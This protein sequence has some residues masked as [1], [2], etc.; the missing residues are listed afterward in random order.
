MTTVFSAFERTASAHGGKPFLEM[1]AWKLGLTYG[2]ALER[3]SGIAGRYRARGY[4]PGHRVA[5]QLETRPEF[6]LHFLAL[7]S[8]GVAVLPLNPDYRTAELEYV[9]AHSEAS[10][11][12]RPR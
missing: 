12:Q 8:I 5:L 3:V 6:L 11:E 4:G 7:N 10:A 2:E 9:L 1:P